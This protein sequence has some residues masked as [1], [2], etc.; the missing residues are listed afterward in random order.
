MI[1]NFLKNKSEKREKQTRYLSQAIQLEE[2]VNPHIIRA[3]MGMICLAILVFLGW[4]SVTS[5]SEV[6]RTP[7][8]VV[9]AGYQQTVQHLEGGMVEAIHVHEGDIVAEGQVLMTLSADGIGEDLARA[10]QKQMALAIQIERQRAFIEGREPDFSQFEIRDS[11]NLTDHQKS[12]EGMRSAREGEGSVVENQIREK[13]QSLLSLQNDLK[14][15]ELNLKIAREMYNRRAALNKK[16]YASDM[17]LL[18]D[19]QRVN[20]IKGEIGRLQK[21]IDIAHTQIGEF[22]SRAT[23]LTAQHIDQSHE[24]LDA[25]L[26]EAAQNEKI[27]EKLEQRIDKLRIK[28]PTEGLIKGFE[29]NTVG[30]IIQPAQK[31]MEIIPIAETFEIEVKISPQDIGHVK[32][33]QSVQ[34]KFAT[35]DFSR[36]GFVKG[37]LKRIS[38]T[39]F[40]GEQGERYYK[41]HILLD[42]NYVG[43]DH[44]NQIIPGMTVMADVITGQKTILQYLL[45]PIHLSLK[46]SFAER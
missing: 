21:N 24:K 35:Y 34:T 46:S 43:H 20:E 14:T 4:A 9:P 22:K 26:A 23:S 7:G 3:T 1:W 13:Q 41:G 28:A 2:A 6:A 38:A 40:T 10:Q 32:V 44:A 31:I 15:A 5:I 25:V 16:G 45:K 17:Q 19:E 27:I 8:E 33:G 18:K 36:Y 12:F 39:T 11:A 30:A 42:K 29:I 37:S